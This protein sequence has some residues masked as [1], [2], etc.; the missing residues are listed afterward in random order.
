MCAAFPTAQCSCAVFPAYTRQVYPS[1][2]LEWG[3]IHMRTLQVSGLVH[4]LLV[5]VA[6]VFLST[7]LY[8]LPP[9][10]WRSNWAS[11]LGFGALLIFRLF[12]AE[13]WMNSMLV[14]A[15][16]L[17]QPCIFRVDSHCGGEL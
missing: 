2:S 12:L 13:Y 16:N 3:F 4:I 17:P 9:S 8:F 7:T 6:W 5:V 1:V 10:K 14:V 11:S 15:W